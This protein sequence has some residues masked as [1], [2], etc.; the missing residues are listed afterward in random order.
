MP[1][2]DQASSY[3]KKVL[4]AAALGNAFE[5]FDF[6][7]YGYL[8]V[9]MS[10]LFFPTYDSDVAL[11]LTLATFAAGFIMRPV[12]GLL[13][14]IYA[15]RVGRRAALTT[16]IWIMAVATALIAF[17]PTYEMAGPIAPAVVLMAR[18]L[19]GFAASGEYGSAVALLA[20]S[21]PPNRKSF[22][23]AWQ[24]TSSLLAIVLAGAIGLAG[25]LFL[26][27]AQLEA[28]GWRVPFLVG[29]LIAPIGYYIRRQVDETLDLSSH[30]RSSWLQDMV[31]LSREKSREL[32]A[33]F[34]LMAMSAGNFYV[35]FVYMPAFAVRE[36]GLGPL[37]PFLSTSVAGLMCA[38][39]GIFWASLVDRGVSARWLLGLAALLLAV[40]VYPLYVWVIAHSSLG[41]LIAMQMALAIPGSMI[42]GL[43]TVVCAQLFPASVRASTLGVGYNVANMVFGGLAPLMVSWLVFLTSD[44]ASAAYYVLAMALIGL[45]GV[46]TLLLPS[47]AASGQA[48]IS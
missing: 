45:V 35:T 1:R 47:K 16:T 5:W 31:L 42:V 37:A 24:M 27:T 39:G 22:Y 44:K 38:V 6:V 9:T 41:V 40:I 48:A 29:L 21:A 4:I 32:I 11:M 19:Q 20:E 13:I 23:I 7:I 25:I 34:A 12:G 36:L 15:D 14:G 46:I 8:A 43:M 17:S 30:R 28:W 2:I 10:R 18:L 3:P 26:T 33:A